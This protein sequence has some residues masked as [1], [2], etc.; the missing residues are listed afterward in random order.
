MTEQATQNQE[1][2]I[3]EEEAKRLLADAQAN[4]EKQVSKAKQ[5]FSQ[6]IKR[7]DER[8]KHAIKKLQETEAMRD[9]VAPHKDHPEGTYHYKNLDLLCRV[10]GANK[11]MMEI[12]KAA[13]QHNLAIA[14]SEEMVENPH[15]HIPSQNPLY[16]EAR[17][18]VDYNLGV[19]LWV[20]NI[21]GIDVALRS[22]MN[23][24][25]VVSQSP[26][27][28][29]WRQ[30]NVAEMKA[31]MAAD[32]E[33][34]KQISQVAAELQETQALLEWANGSLGTVLQLQPE[35]KKDYLGDNDWAK[36]NAKVAFLCELADK[37]QPFPALA[38]HFPQP[39]P[40]PLPYEQLKWA[41]NAGTG[42]LGGQTGRL[43]GQTG[44]LNQQGQTGR[45][46]RQ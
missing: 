42:R 39:E 30:N 28:E 31:A 41:D 5:V 21:E 24:P 14:E 46:P 27:E 20:A 33:L 37:L 3:S 17:A 12:E 38:K 34:A 15:F 13:N 44:R 6:N 9:Q 25:A 11:T 8:L 7:A 1:P 36:L 43:S 45:L 23:V 2:E 19:F 16:M 40:T 32:H 22:V 4:L 29:A 35:A 26:E 18:R 10:F